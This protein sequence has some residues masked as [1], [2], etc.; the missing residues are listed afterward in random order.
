[1]TKQPEPDGFAD[2]WAIWRPH[3]RKTDGRAAWCAHSE[4]R[5]LSIAVIDA[6][7][8][9]ARRNEEIYHQRGVEWCGWQP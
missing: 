4:P 3:A 5:D 8:P 2:F 7:T 1:M 6:M 9:E